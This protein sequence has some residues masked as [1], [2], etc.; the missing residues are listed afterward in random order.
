MQIRKT[1]VLAL[2]AAITSGMVDAQDRVFAV[3]IAQE[4]T[5]GAVRRVLEGAAQRLERPRCQR[6]FD[7]FKDARDRPL[8]ESLDDAG[9]SGTTQLSRLVFYDGAHQPRCKAGGVLAA[10]EVGSHV[11]WI[12][13][14]TFRRVASHDPG[15]AEII[16]IHEALHSLGLGENPPSSAEITARVWSACRR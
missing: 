10:T 6:V 7:E 13:P 16:M 4:A 1:S 5:A 15:T 8:R 9:I 14:E 11:V 12:C 2:A 3:H